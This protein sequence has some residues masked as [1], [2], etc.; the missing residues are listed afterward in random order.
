[1]ISLERRDRRSPWA[2]IA[3][4]AVSIA[5]AFIAGAAMLWY[6]GVDPLAAYAEV[7]SQA[8]GSGFGL[9][10][11]AVKAI[12][13]IFTGLAV[14]LPA[15]MKL[16][17]IGAEG[18]LQLGAIG[19]AWV[20]LWTPLG[21]SAVAGPAMLLGGMAA[22]A[23]WCLVPGALRAWLSVNETIT[24]LL[25]NYVA[26]L[27]VDHL[28]YGPWKD[29]AGRGFPLSAAFPPSAHLP[30]L[31]PG[32]RVH[33]GLALALLA[34][35]A[36]A[37][38]LVRTRWGFEVGIIGDN[39]VAARYAGIG[40][41]RHTLIVMGIAGA[42]AGLAGVGEASAIAGRLQRGLSPG[43]GYTAIIVA[44]LANLNPLAVI[45]VALLMGGLFVGGDALQISFGL[46]IAIVNLLQGLIFF[47]VLGGEALAGYRVVLG[48]RRETPHAGGRPAR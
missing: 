11:T 13:L 2:S 37:W 26:L 30:M 9:A 16:W 21:H 47:F 38:G 45:V 39:P 43:Y 18:Q 27:L 32:T 1:M 35:L 44:W 40:L 19:A 3:V 7:L 4:P 14:L 17:N 24:T 8:F 36:G 31:I 22:G 20:A 29:P 5:T 6:A 42:L 48:R 23:A 15:R 25:M 12:P 33:L 10:E 34:A 41:A 28:I 46:P